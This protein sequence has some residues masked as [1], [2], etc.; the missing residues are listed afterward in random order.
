MTSGG[1]GRLIFLREKFS[2]TMLFPAG[3]G[4]P[5]IQLAQSF[6]VQAP[7]F[8]V[9]NGLHVGLHTVASSTRPALAALPRRDNGSRCMAC[10]RHCGN[11]FCSI[12][13]LAV[14]DFARTYLRLGERRF[15]RR[16]AYPSFF[17]S[18]CT[19]SGLETDGLFRIDAF[20][21]LGSTGVCCA[22]HDEQNCQS[23]RHPAFL[24]HGV[25]TVRKCDDVY[26]SQKGVRHQAENRYF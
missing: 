26:F 23:R 7:P 12:R 8:P 1:F 19:G 3:Q 20:V 5:F 17:R 13:V 18:A 15:G 14:S 25:V 9:A 16:I 4:N 2:I 22:D 11:G 24:F 6:H 10:S 21:K